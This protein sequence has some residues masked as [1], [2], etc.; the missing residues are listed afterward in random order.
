MSLRNGFWLRLSLAVSS[1]LFFIIVYSQYN[2]FNA[3]FIELH[4]KLDHCRLKEDSLFAQ[5]EVMYEH[6]RRMETLM[7]E[8]KNSTNIQISSITKKLASK[9]EE[10]KSLKMSL[11][12]CSKQRHESGKENCSDI[13]SLRESFAAEKRKNE[14]L[15]QAIEKLQDE[16]K[17]MK[18]SKA[19]DNEAIRSTTAHYVGN[20]SVRFERV[21]SVRDNL[22]FNRQAMENVPMKPLMPAKELVEKLRR[23][24]EV[25]QQRNELPGAVDGNFNEVVQEEDDDEHKPVP[26]INESDYKEME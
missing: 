8:L 3:S 24:N 15:Q 11:L 9:E 16:L 6:K 23:K 10:A 26:D 4:G 18:E 12:S 2:T 20:V 7:K 17:S 13:T 22:E 1:L 14:E 5:V 19:V 21:H 25:K